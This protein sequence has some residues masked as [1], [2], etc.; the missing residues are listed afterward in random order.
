MDL[1]IRTINRDS[2]KS[3]RKPA[4]NA[5]GYSVHLSFWG[6]PFS[7]FLIIIFLLIQ[8]LLYVYVRK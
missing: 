6:K 8:K 1:F 7:F 5:I 4:R 2:I 3:N